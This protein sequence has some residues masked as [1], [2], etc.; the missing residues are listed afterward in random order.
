MHLQPIQR[1]LAV[2]ALLLP[3]GCASRSAEPSPPLDTPNGVALTRHSLNG[4]S[5][6]GRSLNGL[7][8]SGVEL[9]GASLGDVRL[10]GTVFRAT[11]PRGEPLAADNLVGAVSAGSMT[12]R[13]C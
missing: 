5:L 13:R 3:A 2:A 8:L 9:R 7:S 1:G 6:N 4:R 11:G 10:D 12:T